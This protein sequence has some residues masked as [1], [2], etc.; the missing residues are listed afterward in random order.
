MDLEERLNNCALHSTFGECYEILN[1]IKDGRETCECFKKYLIAK[2]SNMSELD[3]YILNTEVA[4]L[5]HDIVYALLAS[6]I[7]QRF[8]LDFHCSYSMIVRSNTILDNYKNLLLMKHLQPLIYKSRVSRTIYYTGYTLI[9]FLAEPKSAEILSDDG[10]IN[11]LQ[12]F[13]INFYNNRIIFNSKK[14][15]ES[16]KCEFYESIPKLY[17]QFIEKQPGKNAIL[18]IGYT[19]KAI[20]D[21]SIVEENIEGVIVPKALIDSLFSNSDVVKYLENL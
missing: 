10:F 3:E 20:R 6:S 1:H 7:I 4:K 11:Y 14:H 12:K 19:M 13:D 5:A 2:S 21:A 17:D 8:P 15:P 9:R 18:A 16:I